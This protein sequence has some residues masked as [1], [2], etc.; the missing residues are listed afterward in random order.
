M[1]KNRLFTLLL[2]ALLVSGSLLSCGN[3]ETTVT[4]DT[5]A[6]TAA[7]DTTPAETETEGIPDDK[8]PELDY[9][10]TEFNAYTRTRW[11][12]HGELLVEEA[13]GDVLNDARFNARAAVEE[14]LNIKMT[15]E[16][17]E[18][19]D[20]P[21]KLM[22]AGDDFY[23]LFNTRH[24]N[25]FN[26]ASEK[27]IHKITDIPYIDQTM[28]WWDKEFS[29]Q[30]VVGD[31]QYFGMGAF[32]ITTYDSIHMILFNKEIAKDYAIGDLYGMVLEGTWTRDAMREAMEKVVEDVNGDGVMDQNDQY[33]LLSLPKQILPSFLVGGGHTM[34]EKDAD[35]YIVNNMGT[36][37]G[38]YNAYQDIFDMVWTDNNWYINTIDDDND[39]TIFNMFSEGRALFANSTGKAVGNYRTMEVDF[40]ILPVPKETVEQK[41]YYSRSEFP[42]LQGVSLANTDL[43]MTGAVLEAM[44]S[45]WFRT[46]KPAYFE[47]N[48]RG[49]IARDET[50]SQ[51]LDIIYG[52]RVFD[53]G[54]T[55]LC[56]EI[57]DGKFLANMK[58]GNS[59][60]ASTLATMDNAIQKRLD[61]I[62][63]GFGKEAK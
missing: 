36:D 7:G 62:N 49:K 52:G 50:S 24:V 56:S 19:N 1:K 33:G 53:F 34:I 40:G 9:N 37:E 31:T 59:D 11:F 45:E 58:V 60:L 46:V 28:P 41:Q 39:L 55:I 17:F 27:M 54:D 51:M 48:L 35:N 42:E 20:S 57:R 14:R 2:A 32:N 15:E 13:N 30:L 3:A 47:M 8:L 22:Q 12:F 6:D 38:F 63:E 43:E 18:D 4:E 21:R 44:A 29:D 16:T 61:L 26:Y 25:M 23:E 5:A 10:G